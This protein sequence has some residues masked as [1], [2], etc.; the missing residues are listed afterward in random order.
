LDSKFVD[1]N[2]NYS[3]RFDFS[4]YMSSVMPDCKEY[5][6]LAKQDGYST[7]ERAKGEFYA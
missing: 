5:D 6:E 2:R 3:R 7:A 4:L 1:Y